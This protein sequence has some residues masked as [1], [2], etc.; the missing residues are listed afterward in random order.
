MENIDTD[1]ALRATN[2]DALESKYCALRAGYFEDPFLKALASHLSLD[3]DS[4]SRLPLINRGTAARVAFK[5]DL[6]DAFL[7]AAWACNDLVQIISLG[8][9]YDSLPFSLFEMCQNRKK[10]SLHYV[11]LDLAPVI[12]AKAAAV[13]AEPVLQG[14]FTD[15]MN[16][17]ENLQ[18]IVKGGE[19]SRY[20][21]SSFDLRETSHISG[22]FQQLG[23][24]R[25]CPTIIL[26]E[27]VLVYMNPV[28][29]DA[30]IRETGQ[31]F[32][33]EKA[34]VDIEHLHPSDS[35]G[36]Q[37]VKNIAARGSPLLGINMYPTLVSQ[38]TRFEREGWAH[39]EALTMLDAF[40]RKFSTEEA[41]QL[42]RIEFLDEIEQWN[43][44]MEHYA[45]VVA[46]D[47]SGNN[48]KGLLEDVLKLSFDRTVEPSGTTK[49][50]ERG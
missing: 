17:G 46:V 2:D 5:R 37:M 13:E 50:A 41:L 4:P 10:S 22:K 6:I 24:N 31:Y 12:R 8:A 34:F 36:L 29:S 47:W 23:L 48:G 3:D 15:L 27:I 39:V 33:R 32:S 7:G 26:A 38:K 49:T 43:M 35:F 42:N 19:H 9:G 40:Q 20:V 18:G 16:D 11:E 1:V 14:L 44:L 21:L 30:V 45:I 25:E 28:I